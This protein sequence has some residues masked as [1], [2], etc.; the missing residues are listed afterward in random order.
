[1]PWFRWRKKDST[2]RRRQQRRTQEDAP[3]EEPAEPSSATDGGREQPTDSSEAA[4]KRRRRGSRGGRG[5][6]K[7]GDGGG[8]RDAAEERRRGRARRPKPAS[9][10]TS[11]APSA[12]ARRPRATQQASRAG[13]SPPRR[14][15]L[16]AAKRELLI[17]VDV[18][19]QRVAVLEDEQ[20]AEVYLE[21][22]E[23]RS[24]AGNI[25]LGVVDNVLPGHG[26][27]VRRDRPREERLP[28]RRRDRRARARGQAAR[29]EDP[30]S[31][32]ARPAAARAGGEGPDEDEGRAADDGDL[33]ARPLPRLRAER[34]R[35]R[36]LAPARGRRARSG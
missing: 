26:G 23:R 5:R 32:P 21:R 33:A 2:T 30:G 19:E 29:Q 1:M 35:P 3:A 14:A 16:P 18:G 10:T 34:R 11:T 15:P 31:D 7:P 36:R 28:L 22:P 17:S 25:Y 24:I 6:K 12:A 20:V 4:R 9:A 8:R 13:A 27:R